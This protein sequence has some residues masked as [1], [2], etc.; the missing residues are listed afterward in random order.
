MIEQYIKDKNLEG[1]LLAGLYLIATPIGNINDITIRALS[2]IN[3][4]DY[5]Y[6][7]NTLHTSKLLNYFAIK[8]KLYTYNDHSNDKIRNN[9]IDII[10]II[11]LSRS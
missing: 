2:I 4:I 10:S 8:K 7:E 11:C 6:C 3:K 1:K 9:I 5:I